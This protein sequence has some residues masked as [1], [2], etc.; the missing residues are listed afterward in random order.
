MRLFQRLRRRLFAFQMLLLMAGSCT[1]AYAALRSF[2][3]DLHPDMTRKAELVALSLAAQIDRALEHGFDFDR[4]RGVEALFAATRASS[5]EIMF[6]AALDPAQ[7]RVF[8]DG[9]VDQGRVVP[10]ISAAAAE[11]QKQP[12]AAPARVAVIHN[13]DFLITGHAIVRAGAPIGAVIVGID[14]YYIEQQISEMVYDILIVL[15][16]SL[17][18][19]FELLLLIMASAAVPMLALQAAFS[20]LSTGELAAQAAGRRWP[21]EVHRLAMQM[22]GIVDRLQ[23]RYV[24]AANS[25]RAENSGTEAGERL[26]DAAAALGALRAAPGSEGR[27][28]SQQ[29]LVRVRMPLF[30]FFVAEELSRPFFPIYAR[31]LA[32]PVAGLSPELVVSLPMMLF[33]LV[34][35]L[36]QPLGGPWAERLGARRLMIAGAITAAVGL[37]ATATADSLWT[38]LAWRFVTAAGYGVVFVG[39]QSHVVA[40]TDPGNRAW[41]LAM[42]VGS[43]LAASICGPAIGGILADRIGYRA[44]FLVGS[45]VALL[46]A[47]LAWRLLSVAP[48]GPARRSRPLRIRDIGIVLRNPRFLVL[49]GLGAMPAKIVLT[50]F[51]YYLVPMYLASLGN[52][53]TSAGRIMMLYGLMMVLFTPLA[54]RFADRLGRPLV[55]VVCGG[56][57]SGVG[58]LAALASGS[59]AAVIVGIVV[60]GVAQSVSITPQ[61]ALVPAACPNECKE[62]GQVT[63]IGFF[64][65]FERLGSAIG[66]LLAGFLLQTFGYRITIGAIGCGV[67]VGCLLLAAVWRLSSPRRG[68]EV[69]SGPAASPLAPVAEKA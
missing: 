14:A 23:Q 8:F 30:V 3:A 4:L 20:R 34:V 7:A 48:E 2:E 35:A 63:V 68:R 51:L 5:P 12:A 13:G 18:L 45:V 10:A 55:F 1:V 52:T 49:T 9:A 43:V 26:Q 39:G 11:I 42:F 33:M 19:T 27:V 64:R 41:G 67:A 28:A 29:A 44:T 40:N 61:L 38:L 59:T 21:A 69:S 37:A 65:L 66:P 58:L 47:F 36:S 57:L 50:G 53:P 16:V 6:I 24:A 60:L 62:M 15:V 17:L 31:G 25:P 46:A 54:A 56:L 32:E 22:S